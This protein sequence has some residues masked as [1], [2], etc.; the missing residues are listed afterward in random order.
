VQQVFTLPNLKRFDESQKTI[1]YCGEPQG[2]IFQCSSFFSGVDADWLK[3][4]IQAINPIMWYF[5]ADALNKP[6][7][8]YPLEFANSI[9]SFIEAIATERSAYKKNFIAPFSTLL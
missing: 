8:Y 6:L 4:Q 9:R 7:N 5:V 1:R 2:F 3:A